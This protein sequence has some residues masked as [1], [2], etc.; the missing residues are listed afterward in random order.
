MKN[1]KVSMK[2]IV[3]FVIVLVLAIAVGIIGMIGMNSINNADDALYNENVIAISSMGIIRETYARERVTLRN[4]ALYAGDGA[5]IQENQNTL[6]TLEKTMAEQFKL[7]DGTIVDPSVEEAYYNARKIYEDK[8]TDIKT[9]VKEASLISFE[10]A[11]EALFAPEVSEV[12]NEIMSGFDISMANNERWSKETVDN[13]TGLFKTMMIIEI[14]ILAAAVIIALFLT[15]YISSL[16]SKPLTVISGFLKKAGATGDI[17]LRPEDVKSIE[18]LA[19]VKDEIGDLSNGA[20]LFVKHVTHISEELETVASGDLTT[21]IELLSERDV[22]G[23]SLQDMVDSLNKMFREI[24]VSTNQVSSGSKQVADGAQSLAQ[25]STEQ[26]ASIEELSSSIAEIAQKTKTNAETAERTAGLA[27]AIM[28]NAE[29][30]SRQM[31]E[32]I[33]AVQEINRASQEISKVIKVIDDIAF[34]TN[35]LALNAAV[36]AARAGQHGKGFAVVAEEV[37]SLAQ[38]SAEAARETGEMIQ[39]SM[40]KAELGTHIAEET[41]ASLTDIVSG[42]NE[43]SSFIKKIAFSSE[44]QS[45][46]IDQINIG[47]DQV[48]QVVQQNSATAEESA[49]AS[50]EMSGQSAMLEELISQFKLKDEMQ[51]SLTS[52]ATGRSKHTAVPHETVPAYTP[53]KSDYGKY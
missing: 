27:T 31:D 19:K 38:K 1:M 15:F 18:T 40:E 26:A 25:G 3:S 53:G 2:L 49:A 10:A 52:A 51:R 28:S 8:F 34:Q 4:M 29:K 12:A 23:R 45:L 42:I 13:N 35:I 11:H 39:N 33:T 36:E 7:Y 17:S 14:A 37:R 48:A 43:S 5:K 44:E 32:M 50:E 20:A 41:A 47:I 9:R 24:H 22:M 30:G 46:G 16:I 21:E 6:T